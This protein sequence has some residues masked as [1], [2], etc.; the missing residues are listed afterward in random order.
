MSDFR[1]F[2]DQSFRLLREK[3]TDPSALAQELYSML[4]A[5]VGFDVSRDSSPAPL[6]AKSD[7]VQKRAQEVR[8]RDSEISA[9]Q[10]VSITKN[11]AEQRQD[12]PWHTP[13]PY[14]PPP[15]TSPV[16]RS[17][18]PRPPVAQQPAFGKRESSASEPSSPIEPSSMRSQGEPAAWKKAQ[19]FP[20]S[21]PWPDPVSTGTSDSASDA[22][23]QLHL[24]PRSRS[25]D[26]SDQISRRKR[27]VSPGGIKYWT[28]NP[29]GSD[30]SPY[31]M[32]PGTVEVNKDYFQNPVTTP[33]DP[34]I[35]R[36]YALNIPF[37]DIDSPRPIAGSGSTVLM[38]KVVSG[39]GD[40]YQVDLYTN[41]P[42]QPKDTGGS[43]T[44]KILT[45]DDNEQLPVDMWITGIA[46]VS[47]SNNGISTT[48]YWAQVPVWMA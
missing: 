17:E 43:I 31:P 24:P 27:P 29:A 30:A 48:E 39:T 38:G 23:R 40:T 34:T 9:G 10:S 35:Q 41:G 14:K 13:D 42:S 28:A 47:Y 1:K 26:S 46:K 44:V 12:S 22:S 21:D 18:D 7:E 5:P 33:E 11:L 36:S 16:D 19:A 3:W 20:A 32:G 4:S 6:S 15:F 25:N 45:I 2:T 8:Q 37:P